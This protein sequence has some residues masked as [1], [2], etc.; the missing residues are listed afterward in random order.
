MALMGRVMAVD[1]GSRRVGVAIS[2]ETRTLARPLPTLVVSSDRETSKALTDLALENGVDEVVVG[3]P[4][5]MD[6]SEGESS[7]EA[8][9]LLDRLR[10][11][12]PSVRFVLLDERLS[13]VRAEAILRE[14]KEKFR[15]KKGRLDQISASLLLQEY[16]DS[17]GM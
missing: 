9:R 12:M 2:D 14:R 10:A 15:G 1:W 16:L 4:L 8:Q 5:N 6:G 3:Y 17:E 7:R 11:A 13:S